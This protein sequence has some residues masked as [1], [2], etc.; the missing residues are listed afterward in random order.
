MI[1]TAHKFMMLKKTL[2]AILLYLNWFS[3]VHVVCFFKTDYDSCFLSL[4][5][6][7]SFYE[8]MFGLKARRH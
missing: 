3:L 8:T 1:F 7:M 4:Q 5:K 2:H 6:M